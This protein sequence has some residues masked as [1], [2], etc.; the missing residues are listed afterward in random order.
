MNEMKRQISKSQRRIYN[1]RFQENLRRQEKR[2]RDMAA[3]KRPSL[4]QLARQAI[5]EMTLAQMTPAD[6]VWDDIGPWARGR[7]VMLSAMQHEIRKQQCHL[8]GAELVLNRI[9]RSVFPPVPFCQL[10]QQISGYPRSQWNDMINRRRQWK[11]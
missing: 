7:F 5:D 9:V 11:H 10:D 1:Q 6:V 3:S 4:V 2:L 8:A